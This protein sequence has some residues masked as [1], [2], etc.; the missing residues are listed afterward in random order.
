M[1][2]TVF[3]TKKPDPS[4]AIQLANEAGVR[5]E[6]TVVVGDSHNDILTVHVV[7]HIVNKILPSLKICRLHRTG[8]RRR[9]SE[10]CFNLAR[11]TP[12]HEDQTTTPLPVSF[13]L[14]R[15][16]ASIRTA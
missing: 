10:T 8:Y 6:E 13:C 12:N 16:Q 5:P 15:E 14:Q 7:Q 4:V 2:G 9:R 11:R 1:G 3:P